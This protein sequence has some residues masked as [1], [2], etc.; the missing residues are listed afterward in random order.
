[1]IKDI[2]MKRPR[3]V[4]C[5]P[6][7]IWEF[8]DQWNMGKAGKGLK[9]IQVTKSNI[10]GDVT[11]TLGDSDGKR[12]CEQVQNNVVSDWRKYGYRIT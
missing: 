8:S 1:M 2:G 9:M 11:L 6:T 3:I 7:K 4:A 12:V 10:S 5:L